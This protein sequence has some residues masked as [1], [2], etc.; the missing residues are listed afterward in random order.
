MEEILQENKNIGEDSLTT[1]ESTLLGS[2]DLNVQRDEILN[3]VSNPLN[4]LQTKYPKEWGSLKEQRANVFPEAKII[5]EGR[6][7]ALEDEKTRYKEER[8]QAASLKD[9]IEVNAQREK[10]IEN[11]RI[12]FLYKK[13]KLEIEEDNINSE[14]ER[15]KIGESLGIRDS[16]I[17]ALEKEIETRPEFDSL[18]KRFKEIKKLISTDILSP[19]QKKVI[20]TED[21]LSQLSLEEYLNIW[22]LGS[23]SY[24]AHVTRQGVGDHVAG[25]MEMFA[26]NVSKRADGFISILDQQKLKCT[27]DIVG[28]SL[29]KEPTKEDAEKLIEESN[30]EITDEHVIIAIKEHLPGYVHGTIKTEDGRWVERKTSLEFESLIMKKAITEYTTSRRV[31]EVSKK[32]QYLID[33]KRNQINSVPFIVDKSAIHFSS[34]EVLNSIYGS[35]TGNEIFL[36]FPS[37]FIASQYAFGISDTEKDISKKPHG[38]EKKWND[39]W[40][41]T[42]KGQI[43]INAGIVFLPKDARVNPYTGSKYEIRDNKPI[44]SGN[45]FLHTQEGIDSQTYW[46]NIFN[47][48]PDKRP[49]HVVY[50]ETSKSPTL[51]VNEFLQE[52]GI[53]SIKPQEKNLGFEKNLVETGSFD[54]NHSI[55]STIKERTDKLNQLVKEN[56]TRVIIETYE[57]NLMKEDPPDFE[58]YIPY[59]RG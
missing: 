52:N 25:G 41:W 36:L 3:E 5:H 47:K 38:S 43:S 24:L 40:V 1:G 50:Y 2:L 23:P 9:R 53:I 4:V 54:E 45:G 27:T 10:E 30:K 6:E 42:E 28:V 44:P 33:P 59:F 21:Y 57:G 18:R 26:N 55:T 7:I 34:N 31:A 11:S 39:I 19:E 12:K 58:E 37:D 35:E 51:A 22:K 46:E 14:N 49:A 32:I 13:E 8:E 15:H 17:S 29:E 20:F 16:A 48:D 56:L